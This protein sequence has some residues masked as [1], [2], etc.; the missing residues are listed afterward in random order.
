MNKQGFFPVQLIMDNS[1]LCPSLSSSQDKNL[2]I[3]W[4]FRKEKKKENLY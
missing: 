4:V 1:T 3:L 2:A